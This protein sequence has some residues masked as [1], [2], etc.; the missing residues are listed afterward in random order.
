MVFLQVE[1][2]VSGVPENL[3][4][5]K[6]SLKVTFFLSFFFSIISSSLAGKSKCFHTTLCRLQNKHV[7]AHVCA[8]CMCN[9]DM[10]TIAI[11]NKILSY[12]DS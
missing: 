2:K 6:Q 5:L 4:V 11:V 12:H 7:V 3:I 8:I 9:T 10:F 1:S